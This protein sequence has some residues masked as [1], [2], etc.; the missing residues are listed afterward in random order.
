[1]K[2]SASPGHLRRE[3]RLGHHWK[4]RIAF[5]ERDAHRIAALGHDVT[6]LFEQSAQHGTP[7][8]YA[9]FCG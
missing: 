7:L 3:R 2:R 8:N 1:M 5:G 9:G 4:E 6:L